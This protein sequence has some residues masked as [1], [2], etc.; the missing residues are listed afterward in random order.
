MTGPRHLWNLLRLLECYGYEQLI[1]YQV[2]ALVV[3]V[4]NMVDDYVRMLSNV[5]LHD[6]WM[7]IKTQPTDDLFRN[8]RSKVKRTVFRLRAENKSISF[9][10]EQ[11][12]HYFLS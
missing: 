12:S 7:A 8:F 10:S 2:G 1:S 11:I 9:N 4:E 5:K 3:H 6:Q